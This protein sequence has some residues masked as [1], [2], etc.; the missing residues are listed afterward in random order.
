MMSHDFE[1]SSFVHLAPNVT[2]I[3]LVLSINRNNQ[4]NFRREYK[5]AWSKTINVFI[6]KREFFKSVR[7]N[8]SAHVNP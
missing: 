8:A 4:T 6:S 5:K 2:T 7:V 3:N 1:S